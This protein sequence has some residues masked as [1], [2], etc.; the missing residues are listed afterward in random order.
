MVLWVSTANGT[1]Y[2]RPENKNMV[3]VQCFFQTLQIGLAR[4]W[5][6]ELIS[7]FF[8]LNPARWSFE[9]ARRTAHV[10]SGRKTKT[11]FL[12]N[13]FQTLQIGLA[14]WWKKEPTNGFFLLNPGD[15]LSFRAVSS[16]V[17]SAKRSLTSVFGMRTG[18]SFSLLSPRI[19]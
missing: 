18:G 7:E 8:L 4:W 10:I 14:R 15:V 3:F 6:K 13:V 1:R 16:Q 11:K 9:W 19:V 12:C 5:K 2:F 17:F